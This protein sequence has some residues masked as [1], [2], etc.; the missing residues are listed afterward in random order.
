MWRTFRLSL[1]IRLIFMML[2]LNVILLSILLFV[3]RRSEQ[4]LLSGVEKHAKE[5]TK[6][7]QITIE[8]ATG[9]DSIDLSH[10]R[11]YLAS[12]NMKGI[13]RVSVINNANAIV[14]STDPS[15]IGLLLTEEDRITVTESDSGSNGA[16]EEDA[17]GKGKVMGVLS[18]ETNSYRLIL[19]VVARDVRF[20]YILL[21]I[22]KEEFSSFLRVSD[23]R[24]VQAV[25]LV[26]SIGIFI[27]GILSR[28]YTRPIKEVAEA[29]M[30]VAGG[31]LDQKVEVKRKDEV[32]QLSESFN[33]M[34]ERLREGKLFEERLR[35]AEHLSALGQLSRNVAHEIR[36]PLN[37]INLGI[38]HLDEKYRPEEAERQ[39]QFDAIVGGIKLEIERLSRLVN[40]F[41]DY[42]KP[43]KLSIHKIYVGSLVDD[44]INLIKA[45]AEADGVIIVREYG[46][47]QELNLDKDLF[48]TCIL[49]IF[50]NAFHAMEKSREKVL[51]IRAEK[52]G[53]EFIL[54]IKDTGV[55]V[56]AENMHKVFEPFFTTKDGGLGLGLAIT[57]RVIEEQGGMI[58]FYSCEGK[59][60]EVRIIFPIS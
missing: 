42:S 10:L 41:L 47:G 23:I 28:R 36:N 46:I 14:A 5:L 29:A 12:L 53:N 57:K 32:G 49:N 33:F 56:L 38:A 21:N 19:P 54:S 58:E 2:F 4:R 7:I 13:N 1:N 9:T 39:G 35:E 22:N 18:E 31:D 50:S 11:E 34:V 17:Q 44:A 25:F 24:R 20:G 30:K 60:S 6:V 59:G 40:D 16:K 52:A 3:Y 27:A 8:E 48:K 26:F 55:G 43:I 37:F 45:K 51:T 15:R